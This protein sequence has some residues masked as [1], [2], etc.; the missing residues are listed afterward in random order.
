[1]ISTGACRSVASPIANFDDGLVVGF[2]V[3]RYDDP[4]DR[5][6]RFLLVRTDDRDRA[7]SVLGEIGCS[8][9]Q[10]RTRVAPDTDRADADDFGVAAFLDERGAGWSI[11]DR[12]LDLDGLSSGLNRGLGRPK[13][14]LGVVDVLVVVV[15]RWVLG[16]GY[17]HQPQGDVRLM[18]SSIA[19]CAAWIAVGEP[20]MPTTTAESACLSFIMN[21]SRLLTPSTLLTASALAMES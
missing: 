5:V 14:R 19:H 1:M 20:S 18:A 6:T 16:L 8:R 3:H 12:G 7:V 11:Q 21:S 13:R 17:A 9:T 4:V 15:C 2:V 10:Y